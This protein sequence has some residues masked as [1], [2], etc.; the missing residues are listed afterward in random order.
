VY[1]FQALIHSRQALRAQYHVAEFTG[2]REWTIIPAPVEPQRC[3]RE[4]AALRG[5]VY[6]GVLKFDYFASCH[7]A[8]CIDKRDDPAELAQCRATQKQQ[9]KLSAP[10]I[11]SRG[12]VT[13]RQPWQQLH[14]TMFFATRLAARSPRRNGCFRAPQ[15]G[16]FFPPR[17]SALA[18]ACRIGLRFD[19][20]SAKLEQEHTGGVHCMQ[21]AFNVPAHAAMLVHE[22]QIVKQLAEVCTSASDVTGE[23]RLENHP[24][25]SS[26][27]AF[28]ARPQA[29]SCPCCSLLWIRWRLVLSKAAYG[30][31]ASALRDGWID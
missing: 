24:R 1:N 29:R 26:P 23:V 14:R 4:R 6:S 3:P 21:V 9:N 2:E 27:K 22:L 16:V 17:D 8:A 15:L 28:L 25:V 5:T 11:S 13:I 19:V 20:L 7:G 18:D 10:C 30:C 12:D 31:L